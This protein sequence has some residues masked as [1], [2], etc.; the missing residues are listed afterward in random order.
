MWLLALCVLAGVGGAQAQ[1][2]Q[3]QRNPWFVRFGYTPAFVLPVGPFVSGENAAG[4]PIQWNQSVTFE[5][6][7]QSSGDR[8][9]HRL[10]EFPSY[11]LG[12]YAGHFDNQKELGS[13]VAVYAFLSWPFVRPWER[14]HVTTDL[15]LGLAWNWNEYDPDKN[16]Y[17]TAIG[18]NVTYQFNWGFYLRY[19]ASERVS[20]Y[21]GVDFTHWSNGGTQTPNGGVNVI[22]PKVSLRYNLAPQPMRPVSKPWPPFTPAWEFVAGGAG[23]SKNVN[24]RTNVDPDTVDRNRDFGAFNVTVGLQ[25]HVYHF[26]KLAGGAD[27]TYDGSVGSRVDVVNGAVVDSRAPTGERFALGL[28]GGYEHVFHRLSLIVQVGY[29]VWRGYDDPAFPR[30]YQRYGF[31]WNFSERFWGTLAARTIHGGK[32]SFIELGGGYRVRWP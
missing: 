9:W 7:R 18:S 21:T 11:G 24:A 16:P 30:V 13:P 8:P 32:A 6:G 10:Y 17:N 29:N 5:V 25:R 20:L 1:D 4:T 14:L 12:F 27:L 31:R 28:Y 19:L 2:V 23:G 22:G 15:G 26:S 3:P